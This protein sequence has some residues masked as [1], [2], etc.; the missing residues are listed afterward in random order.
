M[1]DKFCFD[2]K[3][4]RVFL[5]NSVLG[6]VLTAIIIAFLPIRGQAAG[7]ITG[8]SNVTEN[9]FVIHWYGDSL[10][11]EY[12]LGIDEKR[13]ASLKKAK[14]HEV[15]VAST[16]RS[17]TFSGL[18]KGTKYYVTLAYKYKDAATGEVKETVSGFYQARTAVGSITGLRQARW[19]SNKKT[20][21]VTWDA[22]S[23]GIYE[24]VFMNKSGKKISQ[25]KLVSNSFTHTIANDK[26]YCFK[27]KVNATINGKSFDS[28][29]SKPIYLFAQPMVKSHHYGSAFDLG[30]SDGKLSLKWDKVK[31]VDGYRIY[32]SR[33]RDKG[34]KKVMTVGKS[35]TLATV[36]T[37]NGK[38]FDKNRTYYVYVEAYRKRNGVESTS[39]INYLWKYKNG[40]VT[41]TYYHGKY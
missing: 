7:V 29:Y 11:T 20:V 4:R 10:A 30:I 14:D 27:V 34:Y 35:R 3:N 5:L 25:G 8:E 2:E 40:K 37:F 26:C 33:K 23:S 22:Q 38:K 36:K 15:T 9:G 39:G 12:Y 13:D 19:Y 41:E 24:Y 6:V 18:K 21:T 16:D 28:G 32:V 1:T 17:Y 31:N